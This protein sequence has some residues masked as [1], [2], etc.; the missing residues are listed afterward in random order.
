[1]IK[2]GTTEPIEIDL[3]IPFPL[4]PAPEDK[5]ELTTSCVG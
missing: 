3:T 1:M 5:V 4:P 2:V